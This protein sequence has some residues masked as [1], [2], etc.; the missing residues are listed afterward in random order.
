MGAGPAG[1]TA[2]IL[3]AR[4]GVRVRL[5]DKKPFP[6]PKVCGACLSGHA[7][8]GLQAAGLSSLLDAQQAPP[9][10]A[11]HLGQQGRSATLP[12]RGGRVLSRSVFD[13]ALVDAAIAAGVEF[14]PATIAEI[15]PADAQARQVV[16]RPSDS[17]SAAETVLRA[18]L[19]LVATG[20][21]GLTFRG[22][23]AL[24]SQ[25][26]TH[27]R[28]GLGTDAEVSGDFYT[29]GTIFMATHR[30]GYVGAVRTESL[31]LNIAAALDPRFVRSAGGL[32]P[33]AAAVVASAGFPADELAELDWTGTPPLTRRPAGL[34]ANR[35]L[36]LGDAAG[37]VEPFTGEGM[38]W[39]IGSAL[40]ALPL[41]LRGVEEWSPTIVPAWTAA[42]WAAVGRRQR[43]CRT[44]AAA[45]RSPLLTAAAVRILGPFPAAAGPV[46]RHLAGSGSAAVPH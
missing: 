28:I 9:I 25:P 27:A 34:A 41:A 36:L 46:L 26:V 1:A 14:Q 30:A 13:A 24:R 39:A 21:A 45:L 15:G 40:A 12:V 8:A 38:G 6:R 17:G 5:I 20:L 32:G 7:V 23:P 2:A 44:V 37:Y 19:V 3:L 16:I 29:P 10:T 33:A 22:E 4:A 31:A 18:R 35:I 43:M 11:F 42:H